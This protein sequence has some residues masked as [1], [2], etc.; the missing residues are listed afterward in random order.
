MRGWIQT[1]T[2]KPKNARLR[3][4]K[5]VKYI[6][7]SGYFYTSRQ[8]ICLMTMSTNLNMSYQKCRFV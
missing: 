2:Q 4:Y 8:S 7:H 3:G 5:Q 6:K 1:S